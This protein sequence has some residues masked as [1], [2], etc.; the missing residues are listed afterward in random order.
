VRRTADKGLILTTSDFTHDASK[1]AS[2]DGAPAI[3][4]VN[5]ERLVL[6]LGR[7]RLGL[8]PV[9]AYEVDPGFFEQF[10]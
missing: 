6:M 5:G 1:E 10:A 3:E 4:L 9:E 7:A 2:R 8:T